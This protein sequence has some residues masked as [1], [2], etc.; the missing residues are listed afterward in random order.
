MPDSEIREAQA[1]RLIA[2]LHNAVQYDR[3]HEK[4]SIKD[5]VNSF[6]FAEERVMEKELADEVHE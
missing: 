3:R 5:L 2:F 6:F 1:M 4:E